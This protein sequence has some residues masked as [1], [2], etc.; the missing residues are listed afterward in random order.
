[1]SEQEKTYYITDVSKIKKDYQE[2]KID[3]LSHR[4]VARQI[5]SSRRMPKNY[6]FAY[7]FWVYIS[8]FMIIGGIVLLFFKFWLWAAGLIIFGII[9]NQANG[10]SACQHILE[11]SLEDDDFMVLALN[12]KAL[13]PMDKKTSDLLYK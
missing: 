4:R 5:V 11:H 13:V 12:T 2:G 9:V 8:F 10:K 1:M 7:L 3:L 6:R